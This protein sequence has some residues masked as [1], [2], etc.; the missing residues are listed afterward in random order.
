M[1]QHFFTNNN[2]A[3]KSVMN[4]PILIVDDE[5]HAREALMDILET[6]GIP[7]YSA[8]NAREGI[9]LYQTH[10]QEIKLVV[11]DMRLPEMDGIHVLHSLRHINPSVRA[12]VASGFDVRDIGEQFA[13]DPTVHVLQKPFDM[14]RFL[15]AVKSVLSS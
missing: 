11:L 1:K 14:D 4:G 7:T 10:F 15:Q 5:R 13:N 12:I 9:Q 3:S 8:K 6:V 2:G